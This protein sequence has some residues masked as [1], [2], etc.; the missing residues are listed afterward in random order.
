MQ[1]D[2]GC[3]AGFANS[4]YWAGLNMETCDSLQGR[5]LGHIL[6]QGSLSDR[7][8]I[9]IRFVCIECQLFC[10]TKLAKVW[11]L[12]AFHLVGRLRSELP[13][14]LLVRACNPGYPLVLKAVAP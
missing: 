10:G 11:Y 13:P 4:K 6:G 14:I 7:T 12:P 2:F 3:T 8:Q 9:T 5:R 1:S